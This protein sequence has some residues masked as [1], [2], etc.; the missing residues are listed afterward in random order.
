[1][2]SYWKCWRCWRCSPRRAAAWLLIGTTLTLAAEARTARPAGSAE[3]TVYFLLLDNSLSMRERPDTPTAPSWSPKIEELKRQLGSLVAALPPETE[4]RVF[5]FAEELEQGPTA[6]I[7]RGDEREA[8]TRFVDGLQADGEKTRLWRSLDGVLAEASKVAKSRPGK[9]VR[10]LAYTDLEDNDDDPSWRQKVLTRYR[11]LFRAAQVQLTYITIGFE[12]VAEQRRE[13]EEQGL[14]VRSALMPEDV[15]PLQAEFRLAPSERVFPG[16]PVLLVDDSLGVIRDRTVDWGDGSPAGVGRSPRHTY[17]KPGNYRVTLTVIS[18][19]GEKSTASRSLQVVLPPA[20]VAAFVLSADRVAVDEAVLCVSELDPERAD[21]GI[22]WDFGNGRTSE[23]RAPRVRWSVPGRYTVRLE[24]TDRYGRTDIAEKTVVVEGPQKPVADFASPR[25]IP[26][27][28]TV[29]LTDRSRGPIEKWSWF[30]DG[31]PVATARDCEVELTGYGVHSIELVVDGPGGTDRKK[32]RIEV[33]LP[34]P[35]QAHIVGVSET[36]AGV[37]QTFVSRITGEFDQATWVI[38]GTEAGDGLGLLEHEWPEPG[39]YE[40]VLQVRGPGGEQRAS[41][42]VHVRPLPPPTASFSVGARSPRAGEVVRL[43]DTST[44]AI[45][46]ATWYLSGRDVPIVVDYRDGGS[47]SIDFAFPASGKSVVRLRVAGPGGVAEAKVE[48]E[49]R[50]R[51]VRPRPIVT[52]R[53]V[54]KSPEYRTIVFQN[55]SV[56]S[57]TETEIDFGDGSEPQRLPGAADVRHRYRPGNHVARVRVFG[58]DDFVS[59]TVALPIEVPAPPPAWRRHMFTW[60]TAVFVALSVA[61]GALKWRQRL[62]ENRLSQMLHGTLQF[63]PSDD[64][65]A[66]LRTYEFSEDTS[67]AVVSLDNDETALVRRTAVTE[68]ESSPYMIELRIPGA[69]AIGPV[70]LIP[71]KPTVVGDYVFELVV[72]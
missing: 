65:L 17:H 54:E 20:P 55:R 36:V 16:T 38:D 56:G 11:S 41:H 21:V 6:T 51:Y 60:G 42:V 4:V 57:I 43:T 59:A 49:V 12:L 13:L 50:E 68:N 62:R 33:P 47:R 27:G 23:E 8:L 52:T 28:G 24:V 44:G 67:E 46:T 2:K 34:A 25:R 7:S 69:K 63:K 66:P 53:V 19:G 30:F 39:D 31:K 9:R 22:H 10:V 40:V 26:A 5:V 15:I 14:I 71:N 29:F 3:G 70:G 64:P 32:D 61:V 18:A 45:D 58:P 72:A 48:L 1:M 37:P 35:P